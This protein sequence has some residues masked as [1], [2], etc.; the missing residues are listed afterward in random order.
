MNKKMLI[1]LIG[2]GL[3]LLTG[4]TL[5]IGSL[6]SN[7]NTIFGGLVTMF[8]GYSMFSQVIYVYIDEQQEDPRFNPDRPRISRDRL[9]QLKKLIIILNSTTTLILMTILYYSYQSS[10]RVLLSFSFIFTVLSLYT[11]YKSYKDYQQAVDY[12]V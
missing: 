4:A 9:L 7:E 6:F 12:T 1:S 3:I 2:V 5:I 8:L 10:N 11:I